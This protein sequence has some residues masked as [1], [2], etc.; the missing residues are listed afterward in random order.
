MPE[1]GF[2][3]RCSRTSAG[4]VGGKIGVM[5]SELWQDYEEVANF[6][7]DKVAAELGLERVEGKQTLVGDVGTSWEV[8]GKGVKLG[9]EGIVLIE[10]KRYPKR[11]VDQAT[12]G[13][14][15]FRIQYLGASGGILVNPLGTQE[16]GRII[17]VQRRSSRFISSRT[18]RVPTTC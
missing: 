18:A 10:C 5:K 4:P 16:G 13:G 2:H 14:F 11:R 17:A 6:L 9:D 7:L 8:D 12:V 3:D 15:A 1:S